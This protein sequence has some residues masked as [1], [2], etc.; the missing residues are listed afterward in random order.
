M[1]EWLLAFL[2]ARFAS[3]AVVIF[4]TN[5][6]RFLGERTLIAMERLMGMLLAAI[7]VQMFLTEIARL[8]PH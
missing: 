7:A 5:L 8:F 3:T 2:V 6:I 1:L 4:A